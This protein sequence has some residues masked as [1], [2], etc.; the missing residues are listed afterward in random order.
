MPPPGSYPEDQEHED[1][2]TFVDFSLVID[3][4]IAQWVADEVPMHFCHGE[5]LRPAMRILNLRLTLNTYTLYIKLR[6]SRSNLLGDFLTCGPITVDRETRTPS[7]LR[8]GAETAQV[9]PSQPLAPARS[10]M[11]I[12]IKSWVYPTDY[13][14]S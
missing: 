2:R 12:T 4:A 6:A 13:V 7:Q 14:S 1:G 9:S 11:E 8:R 5:P 10:W 3:E